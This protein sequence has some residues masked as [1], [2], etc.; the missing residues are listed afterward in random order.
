MSSAPLLISG[1]L[2]HVSVEA[3]ADGSFPRTRVEMETEAGER[4]EFVV[5]GANGGPPAAVRGLPVFRV[6]DTWQVELDLDAA[7]GPVPRGL[8]A[9]LSP[10]A[11][12]PPPWNLN[13]VHYEDDRIPMVF[14]MNSAGSAD[15][16]LMDSEAVVIAGLSQWTDIQCSAF[17][18][19]Y[20]G[21][22]DARDDD[23]GLNVIAWE[24]E[25]WEW[26][27]DTLGFTAT[28]FEIDGE[29][30][31]PAGADILLNGADWAWI[32][33]PGDMYATTPAL[34]APSVL[35]HELGHATGMDHE[36]LLVASTMFFGY[37][38]GDWQASVSGDDRRGL[39]ENYPSGIADCETAEDCE[40][41]H[42]DRERD[43][44]EIDGM[45]I[46]AEIRDELGAACSRTSFNCP[47]YCIF[48]NAD[49]TAGYCS[50]ACTV[51]EDCPADYHCD[52]PRRFLYDVPTEEERLC[53]VGA[54]EPEDSGHP[55]SG[56]LDSSAPVEDSAEPGG[57]GGVS[58]GGGAKGC[59]CT[60]RS[61]A[62][63][64]PFGASLLMLL[65]MA[66]W[67]QRRRR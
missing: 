49:A 34:N 21:V 1:I 37:I 29:T 57:D 7:A 63:S 9:G 16:G 25:L 43:C 66:R 36:Y 58:A 18:M 35:T 31:T 4:I 44:V 13:G 50:T 33:G 23:D 30:V 32:T 67:G 26:G 24:D 38:G 64:R 6:G 60:A 53:V 11:P 41:I 5:P 27:T 15:L 45:P 12:A 22:T 42:P 39:C 47:E 28:R 2:L 59:G 3:P 65:A 54:P 14:Y 55:D 40:G 10:L 51:D 20:A 17:G 61:T 8:G 46:C 52:E 62:D 48:T 19:E 56:H